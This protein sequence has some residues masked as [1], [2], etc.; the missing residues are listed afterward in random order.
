M[1]GKAR[2]TTEYKL[3]L[4]ILIDKRR[5]A[6]LTQAEVALHLSKPQSHVSKIEHQER[7]ISALDLRLWAKAV[8]IPLSQ[9]AILW[10]QAISEL[11]KE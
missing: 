10:E 7:E 3:L 9:I 5:R 4:D 11:T 6:G 8:G 1:G 2:F